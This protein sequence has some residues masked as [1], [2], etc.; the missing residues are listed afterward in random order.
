MT[1]E[2]QPMASRKARIEAEAKAL[3]RELCDE[4][5]PE[6]ADGGQMIEMMLRR[7]P[8]V[9]YDKLSSP[10]LRRSNLSSWRAR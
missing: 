6:N 10:H 4:P 5:P 2:A 3:W 9:S 7:L 8:D 1:P